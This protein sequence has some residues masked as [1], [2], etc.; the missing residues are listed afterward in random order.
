M[1][2]TG[3]DIPDDFKELIYHS[4]HSVN[5]LQSN[6]RYTTALAVI[7]TFSLILVMY[8][9]SQKRQKT[10]EDSVPKDVKFTQGTVHI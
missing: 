1:E 2:V 3:G 5:A 10:T 6:L 4:T 9:Y 7:I 8:W